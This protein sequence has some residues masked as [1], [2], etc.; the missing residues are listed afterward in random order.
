MCE[1]GKIDT[2]VETSIIGHSQGIIHPLACLQTVRALVIDG[3]NTSRSIRPAIQI[4][5]AAPSIS[6]LIA[7]TNLLPVSFPAHSRYVL[8]RPQALPFNDSR[9][10]FDLQSIMAL[11]F[12]ATVMG[13][14]TSDRSLYSRFIDMGPP[15]RAMTKALLRDCG[16]GATVLTLMNDGSEKLAADVVTSGPQEPAAGMG[17][18]LNDLFVVPGR[19]LAVDDPIME[20]GLTSAQLTEKITELSKSVGR[21]L[22]S[23]MVYDYPTMR[24]LEEA[25]MPKQK[26]A[27]PDDPKLRQEKGKAQHQPFEAR[28]QKRSAA[29][30]LMARFRKGEQASLD[31]IARPFKTLA[32]VRPKKI[33]PAPLRSESAPRPIASYPVKPATQIWQTGQVKQ[34]A[35]YSTLSTTPFPKARLSSINAMGAS[36][37]P[38]QHGILSARLS[39]MHAL[40]V[41]IQQP[42]SATPSAQ[43]S[44]SNSMQG[45]QSARMRSVTSFLQSR[46]HASSF[47]PQRGLSTRHFASVAGSITST[48]LPITTPRNVMSAQSVVV[49]SPTMSQAAAPRTLVSTPQIAGSII[50]AVGAEVFKAHSRLNTRK[51]V[52]SRTPAP[53]SSEKPSVVKTVGAAVRTRIRSLPA[54]LISSGKRISS[55]NIS[56]GASMM[57][58]I[59]SFTPAL[60][61]SR[62]QTLFT[63]NQMYSRKLISFAATGAMQQLTQPHQ[64]LTADAEQV[65][66]S[67]R[68]LLGPRPVSTLRATRADV[69]ELTAVKTKEAFFSTENPITEDSAAMSYGISNAMAKRVSLIR[70]EGSGLKAT[71]P[72]A[73]KPAGAVTGSGSLITTKEVSVPTR[74]RAA[75]K[76]QKTLASLASRMGKSTTQMQKPTAPVLVSSKAL[77]VVAQKTQG[78]RVRAATTAIETTEP[79]K[80]DMLQ[81]KL[82]S[83]ITTSSLADDTSRLDSIMPVKSRV[84]GS[85]LNKLLPDNLITQFR[86]ATRDTA[87]MF[88]AKVSCSGRASVATSRLTTVAAGAA[89]SRLP[90]VASRVAI[91][92]TSA[93]SSRLMSSSFTKPMATKFS[94]VSTFS[95]PSKSPS[96]S[97]AVLQPILQCTSET[98]QSLIS[99][100][101]K[102]LVPTYVNYVLMGKQLSATSLLRIDSFK[103]LLSDKLK[104]IR[105]QIPSE[106]RKFKPFVP[107]SVAQSMIQGMLPFVTEDSPL[108]SGGYDT[109]STQ[110]IKPL[111]S[112]AFSRG[113]VVPTAVP[114]SKPSVTA[115]VLF[116]KLQ[117]LSTPITEDA[118]LIP[119][120]FS[121]E[122][123]LRPVPSLDMA[124]VS[125]FTVSVAKGALEDALATRPEPV[126]A[127]KVRR[128]SAAM[129]ST[130]I[131][132]ETSKSQ[133]KRTPVPKR[134]KIIPFMTA[135]P[136][137]TTEEPPSFVVPRVKAVPA[138]EAAFEKT[139]SLIR[140]RLRS[141]SA[142]YASFQGST[143]LPFPSRPLTSAALVQP[144]SMSWSPYPEQSL[145]RSTV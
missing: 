70:V 7:K 63:T 40:Q 33:E 86:P 126:L 10:V 99:S 37:F 96:T 6:R 41:P 60:P 129:F 48:R 36:T 38:I 50:R 116:T 45:V 30:K 61:I 67:V 39:K 112:P 145:H 120:I 104:P 77:S 25:I 74:V 128:L 2:S 42:D 119:T 80:Y 65:A 84:V 56:T 18:L 20:G 76:A 55:N 66:S 144:S 102:Y 62:R 57:S 124:S 28:P 111:K 125:P 107:P 21:N 52:Q 51:V 1:A 22:S 72:H 98:S 26:A 19:K 4:S 123:T 135:M 100:P 79:V 69:A 122:P 143:R 24:S 23:T 49:A 87:A 83:M 35:R 130:P 59:S 32:H 14:T 82:A 68:K 9:Y 27:L 17:K 53:V 91:S 75:P 93:L 114:Q 31:Q 71:Y 44:A 16:Y 136:R 97:F 13:P 46:L 121:P 85:M 89:K 131:K 43:I 95:K 118:P 108:L 15:K 140:K 58:S 12:P 78:A 29:R 105:D 3:I 138:L 109:L 64:P 5:V 88:S 90:A 115:S 94:Q 103:A 81:A 141:Q 132:A 137:T 73:S 134:A 11:D 101:M 113:L 8:Q 34:P 117:H 47:A 106:K 133:A 54:R 139:A 92:S 127:N 110:P 142:I